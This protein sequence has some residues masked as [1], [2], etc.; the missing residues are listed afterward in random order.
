[1]DR[2]YY[3]TVMRG[4]SNVNLSQK[5]ALDRGIT[6][7]V[8]RMTRG[9]QKKDILDLYHIRE[10]LFSVYCKSKLKLIS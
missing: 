6:C 10:L 8:P 9:E 5:N 3:C 4:N 1:M 7:N 2:V